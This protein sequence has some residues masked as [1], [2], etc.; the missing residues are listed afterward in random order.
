[1]AEVCNFCKGK[2]NIGDGEVFFGRYFVCD[3]C[4]SVADILYDGIPE[5]WTKED[6]QL[7]TEIKD[8]DLLRLLEQ[9]KEVE[10]VKIND[11]FEGDDIYEE[12]I[13]ALKNGTAS[14]LCDCTEC[15]EQNK[16]LVIEQG[17][18]PSK[19]MANLLKPT[20]IKTELDKHVIKQ[21]QAKKIISTAVYNHYIR[22]NNENKID[23]P[24]SNVILIGPT[25]VGKTYTA[26]LIAKM[27]NVPFVS[28][29]VST[30]TP[31]GWKG[32]NID[33]IM[34]SLFI[35]ADGDISRAERGIVLLDE[36]DKA[37]LG[38]LSSSSGDI[39]GRGVQQS[40]LKMIEGSTVNFEYNRKNLQMNT[41]NILFILSGAFVGMDKVLEKKQKKSSSIGFGNHVDNKDQKIDFT[42]ITHEDI[43][44]YG[45]MPEFVGRIS[46]ISV[47]DELVDTDLENI[48]KNTENSLL[49]QYQYL[50][51]KSGIEL[52]FDEEFIAYI[53]QEAIQ[54]KIGARG[55][56][57]ILERE[58]LDLMFTLPSAGIDKY[59]VTR[60]V[61][62]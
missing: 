3:S 48:M 32:D 28:V 49:Q 7:L 17:N 9:I 4:A 60:K 18:K 41:K 47:L 13:E 15:V 38:K 62:K 35:K 11:V 6:K 46:N 57:S 12:L 29:D 37:S 21:E 26:E 51:S 34:T 50:F 56:K 30:L 45:F 55:L 44:S 19:P 33:T 23:I 27:F 36:I 5:E 20:E 8:E 43:V 40:L 59:T 22:V 10:R 54:Q 2:F 58:L 24:K 14:E 53:A 16:P 61:Q 1:M 39:N 31:S 42:K 25:G 52:S